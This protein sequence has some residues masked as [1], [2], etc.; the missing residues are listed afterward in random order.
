MMATIVDGIALFYL[1][2][3]IYD[4]YTG[5]P[6]GLRSATAKMRLIFLDLFFIV[7]DSANLSLA[8][9]AVAH[10]D[11]KCT[12][13]HHGWLK[14]LAGVLLIA[15]LSWI[16]TFAISVLRYVPFISLVSEKA[17]YDQN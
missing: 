15:L 2:A 11:P 14:G 12:K 17:G 7:C 1:I 13:C 16:L 4:E 8:L 6:I 5:K 3:I 10:F 9:M